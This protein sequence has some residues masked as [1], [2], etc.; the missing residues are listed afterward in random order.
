MRRDKIPQEFEGDSSIEGS[1]NLTEQQRKLVSSTT[2]YVLLDKFGKHLA[3]RHNL[4]KGATA[5]MNLFPGVFTLESLVEKGGYLY[6][7]ADTPAARSIK[8]R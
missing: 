4:I 2:A 7:A 8:E 1:H 5:L 3:H 6:N